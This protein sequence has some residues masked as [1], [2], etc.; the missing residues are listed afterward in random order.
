MSARGH[1][2][3]L[4]PAAGG[5]GGTDPYFASVVSLLHFDGA[6]G[7]T[8]FTDV[9]G[10]SWT[11]VSPAEIDTAVVKY[12]SG[13]GLLTGSGVIF[14]ADSDD[15]YF[16]ADFTLELWINPIALGSR[17]FLSGQGD[18]G[19]T[20]LRSLIEITSGGAIKF[21]ADSSITLQTS[22]TISAGTWTH[23]AVTRAGS[24]YNIW[25]NG[26][27]GATTTNATI[28]TNFAGSFVLGAC[29]IF[30]GFFANANY[31]DWRATKGIARY[32]ATFTP[33]TAAFPDS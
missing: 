31:D 4:L 3:L 11:R 16:D 25:I 19:A 15:F 20:D 17:Q 9:T 8:T 14:T 33:P 26:V 32:T 24:V 5:G 29:G 27:S 18:S 6:D 30:G 21:W 1:H 12:G 23:V 7:S 22:G 28:P 13:S 2:G 10:R